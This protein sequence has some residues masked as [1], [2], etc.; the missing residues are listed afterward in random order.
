MRRRPSLAGL[1]T[2]ALVLLSACSDAGTPTP[3]D[4]PS[5]G[6]MP[7]PSR[8][9]VD[10]NQGGFAPAEDI[11]PG[12]FFLPP[13]GDNP[14]V[15]GDFDPTLEEQIRFV[16]CRLPDVP[17]VDPPDLTYDGFAGCEDFTEP[18]PDPA[19]PGGS[20]VCASSR[21]CSFINYDRPT[22]VTLDEEGE[23]YQLK[24]Q[25][26]RIAINRFHRLFALLDDV[27][28]EGFRTG[29]FNV[30]GYLDLFPTEPDLVPATEFEGV[31]VFRWG[32]AEPV[33][34]RVELGAV[35]SLRPGVDDCDQDIILCAEGGQVETA[36]AL[37]ALPAGACAQ[38][39][40][41]VTL[42][43]LNLLD[44]NRPDCFVN[45]DGS[46]PLG[47]PQVGTCISVSTDLL[48]PRLLIPAVVC[49]DPDVPGSFPP[50]GD[51]ET[52]QVHRA[53]R[54]ASGQIVQVSALANA[55]APEC[56]I[57]GDALAGE[58]PDNPLL[59]LAAGGLRTLG[60]W[61]S[62]ASLHAGDGLG[63]FTSFF[64][65]FTWAGLARP[66]KVAGDGAVVAD[67]ESITVTARAVDFTG[68]PMPGVRFDV[69]P[70]LAGDVVSATS[71]TTDAS[72]EATVSV[73]YNGVLEGPVHGVTFTG[74]GLQADDYD[75]AAHRT[76][77]LDVPER[78]LVF[79]ATV[80]GPATEAGGGGFT[81]GQ[82]VEVDAVVGEPLVIT[83]GDGAGDGFGNLL[84]GQ[85]I[86]W[87]VDGGLLTGSD[88]SCSE[89][90]FS[91]GGAVALQTTTGADGASATCW[92]LGEVAGTFTATATVLDET[93]S[94]VLVDGQ[95][96]RQT[97]V[98]TAVAAA[99]AA[100]GYPALDL[101]SPLNPPYD[102]SFAGDFGAVGPGT[103]V[104][105][106]AEVRDRFGNP[107]L[108]DGTAGD[109]VTWGVVSA[110]GG[111]LS[112]YDAASGVCDG[113]PV[114]TTTTGADGIA[115]ACWSL[116]VVE[117]AS[118]LRA[119]ASGAFAVDALPF[120]ARPTCVGREGLG[121]AVVGGGLGSDWVCARASGPWAVNLS[122]GE[123]DARLLW[124]N[125]DT[126]L[127]LALEV[128]TT[129]VDEVRFDFNEHPFLLT[130][131]SG[132]PDLDG[133]ED[134]LFYDPSTGAFEDEHL[135]DQCLNRSQSG[136]GQRDALQDGS[137]GHAVT[138]GK[139]V[140]E[141]AHPLSSG[142][143]RDFDLT[144]GDFVGFFWTIQGGRGAK[145]NSQVT[146]FRDFRCIQVA[147]EGLT[148]SDDWQS[149]SNGLLPPP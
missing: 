107:R 77:V 44:M 90:D 127:Y 60:R 87:S 70:L 115:R 130:D 118:P 92:K 12:V 84:A 95:P 39:E 121:S 16:I 109:L 104:V 97:Y 34:L 114:T 134:G 139:V 31:H 66:E 2:L 56:D 47:L 29:V 99:A 57:F 111:A 67:G 135:T 119:E 72:G 103:T 137:A 125:D 122:G 143:A 3:P 68:A 14:T 32:S 110:G 132:D 129:E 131:G 63:S 26:R 17:R 73:T 9:I 126:H 108:H 18:F 124:M 149:C 8:V 38:D 30:L 106:L 50:F 93:G 141:F 19:G 1:P 75:A 83:V 54:D 113:A 5:D 22:G 10:A 146:G 27:D 15:I 140:Y 144:A 40:V 45:P 69:A 142:D 51:E 42:E 49:L 98:V 112:S 120:L 105:L 86:S 61:L 62:P 148:T 138:G 82:D 136:C 123:T 35:C 59:R 53:G 94:P 102:G 64:S 147:A 52:W 96:L 37:I 128:T 28:G 80:V 23:F 74:I 4:A 85:S 78:T 76:E 91:A 36:H 11:V 7:A 133:D 65:D 46:V 21:D 58:L 55:V 48:E 101:A 81:Q 117:A 13:V 41:L 43:E 89:D 20:N 24:L 6:E 116:P 79:T 33:K 88:G 71:A 145:G 25:E 100:L